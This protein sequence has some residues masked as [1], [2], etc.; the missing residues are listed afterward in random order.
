MKH[1]FVIMLAAFA[2]H[3]A[4]AQDIF[5]QKLYSPGLVLKYREEA[6]L[7]AE[8]VE[9]VKN[10][11]NTELPAYNN[12]K[13]DLDASMAK[14]EQIISQSNVDTK[15]ANAQ[16]EKSLALE[17]DIKKMKLA[18]L[19]KI[20]NILTPAQQA[21]LDAHKD[22]V[23]DDNSIT[24][25]LNTD[26]RTVVKIVQG[27]PANPNVKPLYI[28]IDGDN[29]Q[30]FDEMPKELGPEEIESVNVLKGGPSTAIYGKRGENGVVIITKK[31]K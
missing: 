10:I 23:I 27:R 1:L 30:E 15:A 14:L 4:A 16:L 22:E 7:S 18:T 5:Q 3:L 17:T 2:A 28:L 20:K 25:S 8:Q 21:K 19:L 12:K 26:Q 29:K 11:Y 31:K 13:W 6:G 24:A 9:K